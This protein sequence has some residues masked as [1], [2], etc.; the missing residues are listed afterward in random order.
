MPSER[1]RALWIDGRV[2]RGAF[3]V[4][5]VTAAA[6]IAAAPSFATG[7]NLFFWEVVGCWMLFATSVNLLF[8]YANMPSF[9][10]AAYFGIG[11]YTVG[12]T[13][14]KLP[15]VA[16]I[17]LSMA[18]AGAAAAL[19]G[20]VS[21]RTGGIALANITLAFAQVLYLLTFRS[22]FVGGEN[23][24][25]GIVAKGLTYTQFWY[26]LWIC[27]ALG[28]LVLWRVVHSPFG[29]VLR[30]MREDQKRTLFLGLELAAYRITAFVIS[31]VLAGL[32]GALFAYSN[33]IV[34]PDVLYWTNSGNPIIM[35]IIGG[36]NG[37]WGPAVGAILLTWANSSLSQATR[38]WLLYLGVIL[39]F[40][41][42]VL[43]NGL[44]SLPEQAREH[45]R[46]LRRW[47]GRLRTRA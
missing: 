29:Y 40:F 15:L 5:L 37:F 38:A 17:V 42:T 13:F 41:L 7:A 44:L 45:S 6:V 46:T 1:L 25:P 2:R 18:L 36:V 14:D 20:T 4:A 10:Q 12:M 31:G 32:A 33:Q 30:A 21:V 34:T 9:G 47:A 24:L 3:A 16:V 35:A 28:L 39:L 23:G 19:I 43:P 27:V 26:L 22:Q 11:A 8:G